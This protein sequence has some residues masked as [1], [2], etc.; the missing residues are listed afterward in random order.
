MN[1][2]NPMAGRERDELVGPA[3]EERIVVDEESTGSLLAQRCEGP[4]DLA[5][6]ACAL[7]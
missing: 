1:R 7:A 3:G 2:G 4:L 5:R 6:G